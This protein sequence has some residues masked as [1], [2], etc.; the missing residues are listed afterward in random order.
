V[1]VWQPGGSE[2]LFAEG[3]NGSV[4]VPWLQNGWVYEF[5]LYQS[6][7]RERLSTLPL[8]GNA[9]APVRMPTGEAA[10]G[11]AANFS[12]D[13]PRVTIAWD[14]GS[15]EAG[16]V[17]WTENEGPEEVFAESAIGS[18]QVSLVPG[19]TY[20]FRLYG[21]SDRTSV[22]AEVSAMGPSESDILAGVEAA[23]GGA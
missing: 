5:R 9:R 13:D 3:T 6:D 23:D 2:V 18:R 1:Y 22:L 20:L 11:L 8:N 7:S 15:A 19:R 16:V 14:T 4:E 17:T 21:Q 12:V 10:P